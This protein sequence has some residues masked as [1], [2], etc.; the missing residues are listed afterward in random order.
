MSIAPSGAA[1]RLLLPLL[2]VC[3]L[4]VGGTF[5]GGF[6][7]WSAWAAG[8]SPYPGW[9]TMARAF[10]TVRT[11][12]VDPVDETR[13]AYAAIEGMTSVLDP[14]SMFFDP[15]EYLD[16]QDQEKRRYYGIGT[17][18]TSSPDG[19]LVIA[20]MP[21]SP[22]ELAGMHVQDVVVSVNG[23]SLAG[24]DVDE[25]ASKLEGPRGEAVELGV[26][27]EGKDLSFRVVRDLV[28]VQAA[29]GKLL[30]KGRALVTIEEF[31]DGAASEVRGI[32]RDLQKTNGEPLQ[33]VILDVRNDPGGRLDEAIG[34]V[35]L[36][37]GDGLILQVKDR[38][39]LGKEQ[40]SGK[41]EATDLHVPVVVLVNGGSASASEI[42]AGALRDLAGARLVGVPTYGKASVQSFWEFEDHSALKLTIG[43]YVLP[44]GELLAEGKGLEPDLVVLSAEEGKRQELIRDLQERVKAAEGLRDADREALTEMLGKSKPALKAADAQAVPLLSEAADPQLA[45]AR[46]E[47]DRAIASGRKE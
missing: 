22:A 12:Y 21:K 5:A 36:F 30:E 28:N 7:T 47:L 18:V 26:R 19:L 35:D 37:V 40:Y 17:Q 8:S 43:H 38:D 10:Y 23:S 32:L 45:Q 3:G 31:R 25:A 27:R 9:D 39:G 46:T 33:G 20:V 34:V 11:H 6:V 14:H 44:R 24:L 13:M 15:A 2:V 4:F 1:R 42:V 29:T 41:T 16:L